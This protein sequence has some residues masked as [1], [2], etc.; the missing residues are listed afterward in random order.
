M[1]AQIDPDAAARL[2]RNIGERCG[3]AWDEPTFN[4]WVQSLTGLSDL[5]AA[6][7]A[8]VLLGQEWGR[9]DEKERGRPSWGAFLRCYT[10]R[11]EHRGM[12][13][14]GRAVV[15]PVDRRHRDQI[16]QWIA[17]ARAALRD[18]DPVPDLTL[19]TECRTCSDRG[20][21]VLSTGVD[22][23]CP[24]CRPDDFA[25]WRRTRG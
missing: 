24:G 13:A 18:G 19:V 15:P 11:I 14:R 2:V 8:V 16:R 22:H 20:H 17:E 21:V 4:S 6:Q 3:G 5:E 1:S 7:E 12:D 10:T 25:A 9:R 23:P